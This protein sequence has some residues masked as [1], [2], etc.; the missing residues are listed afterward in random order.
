MHTTTPLLRFTAL[1]RYDVRTG[2]GDVIAVF[3]VAEQTGA[4][5]NE[6]GNGQDDRDSIAKHPRNG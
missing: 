6:A 1:R 3:F 2:V 4:E 5:R